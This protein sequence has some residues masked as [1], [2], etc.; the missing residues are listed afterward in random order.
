MNVTFT[1]AGV[2]AAESPIKAVEG[3][4]ITLACTFWAAVTSPSAKV[5]RGGTEYTSVVMPAGSAS[6][7]GNVATLKPLTALVGGFRYIVAVSGTVAGDVHV[8]KIEVIV[9]RDEDEQ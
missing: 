4:T 9:G 6:A 5:Y 2:F 8:K 3:S 1:S 7:S